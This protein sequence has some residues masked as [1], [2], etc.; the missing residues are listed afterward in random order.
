MVLPF[1]TVSVYSSAMS[2][3]QQRLADFLSRDENAESALA[4]KV[5]RSQASVN[6][7]RNGRRFPDAETARL[8]EAHTGGEVAFALWQSEFLTR[9]G[10][11]PQEQAA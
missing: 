10:I 4:A 7:Y 5:G 6:R 9:S 1:Y 2:I 8:I 11:A 3:Y